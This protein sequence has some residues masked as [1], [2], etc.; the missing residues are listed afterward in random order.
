M[1]SLIAWIMLRMGG[2]GIDISKD[3]WTYTV[4]EISIGKF[5]KPKTTKFLDYGIWI[6]PKVKVKFGKILQPNNMALGFYNWSQG[7]TVSPN[8][9]IHDTN[10]IN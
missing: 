9:T 4:W 7:I 8:I 10:W 5:T 1:S 6:K 3:G 2:I